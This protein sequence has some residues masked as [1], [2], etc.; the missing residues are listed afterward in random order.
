MVIVQQLG[1]LLPAQDVA[2][3]R[4]HLG[5]QAEIDITAYDVS[6]R[7]VAHDQDS[8]GVATPVWAPAKPTSAIETEMADFDKYEVRI[9][10]TQRGRQ[11]VAAIEIISPGYKDRPENRRQFAA[12]MRGVVAKARVCRDG[13]FGDRS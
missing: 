3:P 7:R 8:G 1:K 5:S 11:L 10:D 2:A 6:E 9:Y 4:V 12:Q 13:G